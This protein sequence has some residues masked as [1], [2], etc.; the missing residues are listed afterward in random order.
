MRTLVLSAIVAVTFLASCKGD[1][2]TETEEVT[3]EEVATKPFTV[4]FNAVVDK[5][6]T[7]QVFYNEDAGDNF[8]PEDAVTINIKGSEE[9]QDLVFVMPEDARPLALR[10]D[11]GANKELGKVPFNGFR[12]EYQGKTIEG[13][14]ADFFKYFYPNTQVEIDTI[15]IAAKMKVLNEGELYDPILGSTPEFKKSLER[16]YLE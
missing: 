2:S 9:P 16:L 5:D 11:I 7:F 1:K 10:F 15:N 4:T 12:I 13:T 8:A 3:V 14:K 6:D